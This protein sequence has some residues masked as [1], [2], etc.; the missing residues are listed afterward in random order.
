MTG[1]L[2]L[3]FETN[4]AADLEDLGSRAYGEH[5]STRV[6]CLGYALSDDPVQLWWPGEPIPDDLRRAIANGCQVIAHNYQ[7]D[8]TV[9]HQHMVP[10]GWPAIPVERWSC[11]SFRAR[12]AR[13][14]AS[15]EHLAAELDQ[16][17]PQK[18]AAGRRFMLAIAKRDLE[19][20]PLTD[21]ERTRLGSYCFQDIV[22]L[23]E[24]D[25]RLPEI[26]DAWRPVFEMD[27][28]LNARGMPIDIAAVRKLIIVRDAENVRLADEFK[29]LVGDG[30]LTSPR[31][32]SRLLAKLR[33]LGVDLPDLQRETL[34]EWVEVN[35][36]RHDLAG[37]LIRNRLD[38]A[39]A[40]DSKLDR[41]ITAADGTGRV[42]DSFLLHGAHTARWA[43]RGVQLQNLK[44]PVEGAETLLQHL[45]DRADGIVAGTV[46]PMR[47]PDW[48]MS[49]K[50]SIANCLRGLCKA[51]EKWTIVS[52]DLGQIESRV[53]CWI[54]GQDDK[55]TAYRENRDVYTLEARDLGSDS[56]DL[57][58]LFVLSAGY[59]ASGKV[60]FTKA[61]GF[62]VTLTEPEAYELTERWRA[63]NP[64]I[65]DFW[66]ETMRTLMFVV[67]MPCDQ[68]PIE[69]RGLNIWRD[70]SILYVQLPSGR[71]LKYRDPQLTVTGYGNP[72][73]S[74]KLPKG[75]KLLNVTLWHGA[76]CENIIS[77]IAFDIM[78]SAMLQLHRGDIF[79]VATIH[80]QVVALAPVE[81]AD[82]IRDFMVA[83]MQT[84]PEWAPDLPLAADA[85]VNTRFLK[86]TKSAAHAPL[87]P[88]SAERWMNCPGSVGAIAAMPP[89]P[90]AE[91]FFATEGTEAH[92]IFAACLE[93]DLDPAELTDDILMVPPL[94]RAL[95]VA[96]DLI[97]GRKFKVEIRLEP[98]ADLAKVWGTADVLVFDENGY[99]IAVVDL[100]FG[101]S[102]AVEP[103]SLQLQIYALLAAQQYGCPEDG[104]DL[105]VLQPRR[106]H[107][108]GQH[109]SHHISTSE[110]SHLYRRLQEVVAA[111]E[112]PNAPRIPGEQCRYCPAR[113]ECPEGRSA[114]LPQKQLANPF[115][116]IR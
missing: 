67:E 46:D 58:K 3:D 24:V 76:V 21:D 88:S 65:V 61:P 8:R 37:L 43:G 75:K 84:P 89:Q 22:V 69:Y 64:K 56:R 19:A 99:V 82:A 27:H 29:R 102:V 35:P 38:S 2:Y 68:P 9:W 95:M 93:R 77:G 109:R 114:T 36:Q 86:P 44:R 104:I 18:D 96:R 74:V 108:K 57:G 42:R 110:L 71:V 48:P 25:R 39:H 17:M 62:G 10:L 7:F 107:A 85:F 26:P 103:D 83:V 50:E 54:A 34:E 70:I 52:V 98:I 40:A 105:H 32:V 6:L 115:G 112:Q 116:G 13:L 87:P 4:S 23:R 15:L 55:L 91:S 53:L 90:E 47:A 11:T 5:P 78:V 51:P 80:D 12:L 113:L 16:A 79:L 73:L 63:N 101:A 31:Q 28:A 94:R 97:G 1:R 20:K 100:K 41:M 59:G 49:V 72:A 14:P 111:I 106:Q 81:A 60:M 92:R 45:I 33:G 66:Y 30:D